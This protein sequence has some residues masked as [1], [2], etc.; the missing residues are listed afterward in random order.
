MS[1][2]SEY[3]KHYRLRNKEKL[4]DY[5]K[6][7]YHI[8][9]NNDFDDKPNIEQNEKIEITTEP[10]KKYNYYL[11]QVDPHYYLDHSFYF[12]S[13]FHFSFFFNLY[14]LWYSDLLDIF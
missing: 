1:N 5:H 3:H 14:C 10:I 2:R 13:P 9:K 12:L 11:L 4:N 8:K 6:K 7:Y